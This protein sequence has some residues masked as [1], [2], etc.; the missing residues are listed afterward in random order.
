M[1]AGT[2]R[3]LGGDRFVA[4]AQSAP[5][6]FKCSQTHFVGRM[7]S[8]VL[9]CCFGCLT[10]MTLQC[11]VRAASSERSWPVC[12]TWRWWFLTITIVGLP[13]CRV[14]VQA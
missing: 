3:R 4:R 13:C 14:L 2:Y 7:V 6:G 5:A 12:P 8:V 11:C 1:L 10:L 9:S